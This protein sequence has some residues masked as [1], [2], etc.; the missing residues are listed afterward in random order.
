MWN[1]LNGRAPWDRRYRRVLQKRK[2]RD[3]SRRRARRD[4]AVV[5]EALEPRVLLSST[6]LVFQ[7]D[8][9]S[10]T[11][12]AITTQAGWTSLDATEPSEGDNVS[13]MV[14]GVNFT[15]TVFSSDGSRQ[16]NAPNDLTSDFIYDDGSGQAVGLIVSGLPAGTYVA[17]VWAWDND[18]PAIGPQI[19]GWIEGAGAEHI[20]TTS[21]VLDPDSPTS[22]FTF[23]AN[24]TD[25]YKIFTR[26]NNTQNASRFNALRLTRVVDEAETNEG[27]PAFD[28][29]VIG[30]PDDPQ[31]LRIADYADAILADDPLFYW[32]LNDADKSDGATAVNSATGPSSLGAA[33][34]GTYLDV[35]GDVTD[36]AIVSTSGASGAASM[37]TTTA[38]TAGVGDGV[39][40]PLAGTFPGAAVTAEGWFRGDA[41]LNAEPTFFSYAISSMS[42]N[43]FLSIVQ[44]DLGI[45]ID[46][47]R[48]STGL[49][50][51]AFLDNQWH[52]L[53]IA[54]DNVSG[55]LNLYLDGVQRYHRA[56][57]EIGTVIASTGSFMIGQ[58]Q[59]S[60][61]GKFDNTQKF[62][63]DVDDVA[64]YDKQ[65]TA[66]QVL[67]HYNAAKSGFVD[68]T[69]LVG[70]LTLNPDS[71]FTYDPSGAD[72]NFATPAF[73]VIDY[74]IVTA[75]GTISESAVVTVHDLDATTDEDTPV[76]TTP[77]YVEAVNEDDPLVYLRLG[78]ADK[79]TG[80]TAVNS[81][82]GPSSLGAAGDGSYLGAVGQVADAQ[83]PGDSAASIGTTN[84]DG[85][86]VDFTNSF[87]STALTAE[88]WVR[89]TTA[90]N[91]GQPSFFSYAVSGS[92]NEFLTFINGTVAIWI[93]GLQMTTSLSKAAVLDGDWHQLAVT[94]ASATGVA[95]LY[96]DGA[97]ADTITGFKTGA[98]LTQTGTFIVG[99]EQDSVGGGFSSTQKFRGDVDELAIYDHVLSDDRI[100]QHFLAT[101]PEFI[102]FING[103]AVSVGATVTLA[104]GAEVT[105]NTDGTFT[106][107]PTVSST[108]DA[109]ET[110]D[111]FIESFRY[112]ASATD[113]RAT[114]LALN[115]VAYYT[116]DTD[117]I[118][119]STV[120]NLGSLTSNTA[121]LNGASFTGATG[122]LFG[123][124]LSVDDDGSVNELRVDNGNID[125]GTNWTIS[126]WFQD[127][128]D[129]NNW[130]TLARGEGGD[131]QIIVQNG[132][133]NL[134]MYDNG[135]GAFRDSG[136]DLFPG[137]TTWHHIAAVGTGGDSGQTDFY[138]D[139]VFVGRSD[140]GSMTDIDFI[141]S[142]SN[143]VFAQTIDEFAVFDRALSTAE[144]SAL[145]GARAE[146][147]VE[148]VN[149]DPVANA[150]AFEIDENS[151]LN[152]GYTLQDLSGLSSG[153][154]AF[155]AGGE[156]FDAYVDNDG[157]NGWLLVGR[158]REGWEFDT[159]G[160]GSVD[161]VND[162]LGT[163][164]AFNPAA[165]SEDLIND[166]LTQAGIDLS[167]VE[168]R[169]R[170]AAD[171]LGITWQEAVWRPTSQTTWTWEF[172][173]NTLNN[174][175]TGGYDVDYEVLSGPGAG[176]HDTTSNTLD[177]LGTV[178][179]DSGNDATRVFTWSW[180]GHAGVRGFS[181]GS[182]VNNGANNATSFFWESANE[183]HAIPYAEIYIRPTASGMVAS[184]L[185]LLANDTDAESQALTV[186]G[187]AV[188]SPTNTGAPI[189]FTTAIGATVIVNGDGTFSYDPTTSATAGA[190]LAGESLVDT[191]E[192]LVEDTQGGLA[193]AV[194]S[195]TV[196]GVSDPVDDAYLTD[197]DT[198]LVFPTPNLLDNDALPTVLGTTIG[199]F[200]GSDPGEG[201]DLSGD[202]VYA[203]NARGPAVGMIGDANFTADTAPGVNLSSNREILNWAAPN[204]DGGDGGSGGGAE[205][206]LE[207]IMQSIRWSTDPTDVV[208]DLNMDVVA[209]TEYKLQLLFADLSNNRG[210][211]I[212]VDGAL[213]VDN[214]SS[215]AYSGSSS[216]PTASTV[217]THTFIAT[218]N[219]LQIVLDGT[220][221]PFADR[222][223]ILDGFT[224]ER[225]TPGGD[226][227]VSEVDG[228]PA[229]VNTPIV[230]PSGA[231][232]FVLDN[233]DFI[234]DPNGAFESLDAGDT[235][236]D[237]F[238]YTASNILNSGS[239]DVTVTIAGVNDA[240]DLGIDNATVTVVETATALNTGTFFDVEGQNTTISA[241]L[242]TI[243]F[244]TVGSTGTWTWTYT[245]ADGPADSQTVT[246]T[247]DDGNGGMTME[248]FDLVVT[249]VAPTLS[250]TNAEVEVNE[251]DTAMNTGS[252]SDISALDTVTITASIGDIVQVG[253]NPGTYTWSFDSTNGPDETQT[254]TITATDKD[255]GT[256]EVTFDLIVNNVPPDLTIDGTP[257][258]VNEGDTAMNT[259]TYTDPG[260]G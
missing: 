17:E 196:N 181:Y 27:D 66:D 160:Q 219:S 60:P 230:L 1:L 204:Y 63:G 137:D 144:I 194:V 222:N 62:R 10:S 76:T 167:S 114:V 73:D 180:S 195:V 133:N 53:A 112:A 255:G 248:T 199:Y 40:V 235:A 24:G 202:F 29:D 102:N 122:G 64:L 198:A 107:D 260:P 31:S 45:F 136:Y 233:G 246:I 42:S 33:G 125:L 48:Y 161:A 210:F 142:Y 119:G 154:Y 225:G 84:A 182:S 95:T 256:M 153:N 57:T 28:I 87:P 138:I 20:V 170:R 18:F 26:E 135:G 190:L 50:E 46:G 192:Y 203:V 148:G 152:V 231:L 117:N 12:G 250:V 132:A 201:L 232:L 44:T 92:D 236:T 2:A 15:A 106:Y 193:T 23:E 130:R 216:T 157:A 214:F 116:F 185:G 22:A 82:T 5:M 38:T 221:A 151:V 4:A 208:V 242:G 191:F 71:S 78:D 168:I 254:V 99:Q 150:D 127:L 108:L 211:D 37:G 96:F 234:Y 205:G 55:D 177:A 100:L 227:F 229:Y 155:A 41:A 39:L 94:W 183:D 240:P 145:L 70:D 220:G 187:A 128:H 35:V 173:T 147:V 149:D 245:T 118:S 77:L 103:D 123:G 47:T 228:D 141:G 111:T 207:T 259:G 139:G 131:H 34:D 69:G 98:S 179:S 93:D 226:P 30:A 89:G 258:I 166:L 215:S 165:Y 8:I 174:S 197:E 176:F 213:V 58:E 175:T 237:T 79:S 21:A 209:G 110:G 91:T 68:V 51:A 143:Q 184:Q 186:V 249:N 56:N 172:S 120:E 75:V 239:A 140:S 241:S 163:S 253:T 217:V 109:M 121:T 224:L 43:N 85:V 164:A 61:G 257:I 83:I 200:T 13:V 88:M 146:I 49:N 54:W 252:F 6:P 162:N 169:I 244:Q 11:G 32:Q 80:A 134:G 159:D 52:H 105:L 158:G 72:V 86:R 101:S 218:S 67:A 243:T 36:V 212:Y 97:V 65:L 9:D 25:D 247:A 3:L 74:T 19:V 113:Y 129:T 16:R 81:A 14:G 206:P 7:I 188:T 59:D 115:P 251:G 171:P 126:A 104:S 223:P 124:G 238:N 90:N 189:T 178:G 156:T